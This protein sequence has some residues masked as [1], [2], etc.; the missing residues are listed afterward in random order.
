MGGFVEV[1]S[2]DGVVWLTMGDG[3]RRNALS[4]TAQREWAAANTAAADSPGARALVLIGGGG[5]TFVSGADITEFED[6]LADPVKGR[7]YRLLGDVLLERLRTSALPTIAAMR[8]ACMGIGM[9]IAAECDL[10]YAAEGTVF[11]IPAARLGIGYPQHAVDRLTA[12]VG[13]ALA[14]EILLFGE[15][16][17]APRLLSAGFL[18][19]IHPDG[20]LEDGV[21]AVAARLRMAAPLTIR[22]ARLS[23]R[24]T[25]EDSRVKAEEAIERC[26]ASADLKEGW[27]AFK[28]KRAPRFE[29]G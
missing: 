10:R 1:Q 2:R 18:S 20:A 4:A 15:T 27:R 13:P 25:D 6:T 16:H 28:E 8:G 23:L 21:L 5:K 29:G 9:A 12:L 22:A 7:D 24:A 19:G 14:T 26:F 3:S 11:G 17:G